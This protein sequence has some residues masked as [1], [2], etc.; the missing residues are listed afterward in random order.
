MNDVLDSD[1][2]NRGSGAQAFYSQLRDKYLPG[3]P[4]WVT[5]TGEASCGGDTWASDFIDTFRMLDQLGALAQKSVQSVMFNTL[6]SSDYGLI[7][8]ET[9]RPRPNYWAAL[10]WDRTMGRRSLDPELAPSPGL[11][12][13]AQC[14]KNSNGGVAVLVLNIDKTAAHTLKVPSAGIR[15]TLSSPDLLSTA[16][17]LNGQELKMADDGTVPAYTGDKVKRGDVSFEPATI[18]VLAFPAAGNKSCMRR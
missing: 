12:V 6:A 4:M 10:L 11:R 18:T 5:E 17:Q 3:K 9:L 14:L 15:Y 8:Q 13:Y 2:L 1:W 16:V 7:D